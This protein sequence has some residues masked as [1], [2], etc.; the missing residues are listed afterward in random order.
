MMSVAVRRDNVMNQAGGQAMR[1]GTAA[2]DA[3]PG[4][5]APHPY[6]SGTNGRIYSTLA[7]LAGLLLGICAGCTADLTQRGPL[8]IDPTCE[9]HATAMEKQK[10]EV[11]SGT[12]FQALD[13]YV[14]KQERF[15][16]SDS[17]RRAD[18]E[19]MPFARHV[20]DWV[21]PECNRARDRWLSANEPQ[22]P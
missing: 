4:A 12:D 11:A 21:C 17:P 1:T 8:R 2:A 9:V 7:L 15:P 5:A 16:H 10:L 18:A 20:I 3:T 13:W 19:V 22:R 14:V 6:S